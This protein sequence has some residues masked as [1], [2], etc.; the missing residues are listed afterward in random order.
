[1]NNNVTHA[2]IHF[3]YPGILA[4]TVYCLF[5][6]VCLQTVHSCCVSGYSAASYTAASIHY[7]TDFAQ[8]LG[9][10]YPAHLSSRYNYAHNW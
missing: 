1:M 4:A 9:I 8:L 10:H 3:Y 7:S 6:L 2:N 5:T